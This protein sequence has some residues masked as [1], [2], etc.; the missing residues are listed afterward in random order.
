MKRCLI[1]LV[2][3]G[4]GSMV[5]ADWAVTY[6]GIAPKK[7]SKIESN[8]KVDIPFTNAYVVNWRVVPPK[9]LELASEMINGA[10]PRA[11]KGRYYHVAVTGYG[12]D[13]GRKYSLIIRVLKTTKE[14]VLFE[15][16]AAMAY[17]ND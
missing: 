9:V 2:M 13:K 4:F 16:T 5:Y 10:N 8:S 7:G 3:L 6:F 17:K 14:D 15:Y 1:A 11:K 12:N